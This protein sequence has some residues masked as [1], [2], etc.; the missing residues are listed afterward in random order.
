[1]LWT[2]KGLDPPRHEPFR[3]LVQELLLD[4]AAAKGMVKGRIEPNEREAVA[5]GAAAE[6]A[7]RRQD[8]SVG[9]GAFQGLGPAVLELDHVGV[10]R[11]AAEQRCGRLEGGAFACTG[12]EEGEG[13]ALG[14]AQKRHNVFDG[15]AMGGINPAALLSC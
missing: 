1:F 4:A 15:G 8:M 10:G 2:D 14:G 12:V 13:L 11:G 7:S 9:Q 6:E 5:A 3:G